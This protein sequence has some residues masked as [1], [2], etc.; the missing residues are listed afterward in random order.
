MASV[1]ASSLTMTSLQRS[2]SLK[3]H[4]THRGCPL[5]LMRFKKLAPRSGGAARR[6]DVGTYVGTAGEML[7]FSP[8][9]GLAPMLSSFS[10]MDF[11]V[12][13]IL[14]VAMMVRDV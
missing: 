10:R 12:E 6:I 4:A 11:S 14:R 3:S 9:A 2:V 7:D 5:A 1:K 8:A 13:T